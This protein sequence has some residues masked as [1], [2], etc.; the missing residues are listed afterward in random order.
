METVSKVVTRG[1]EQQKTESIA[2]LEPID[3]P[4]LPAAAFSVDPAASPPSSRS[5]SF[6]IPAPLRSV[7]NPYT[8][9]EGPVDSIVY[10]AIVAADRDREA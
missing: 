6:P 2:Y 8:P 9:V 1:A 4:E 3:D 7:P 5:V 10:P